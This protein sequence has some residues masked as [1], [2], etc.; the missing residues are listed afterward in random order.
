MLGSSLGKWDRRANGVGS[1]GEM[2][3]NT[4][5]SGNLKSEEKGAGGVG[6]GTVA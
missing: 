5:V 1:F 4:S 6:G 2:G 3:V